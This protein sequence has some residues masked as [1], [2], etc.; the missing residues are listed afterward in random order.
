MKIC[1]SAGYI[2]WKSLALIMFQIVLSQVECLFLL[3]A[4]IKINWNECAVITLVRKCWR[5]VISCNKQIKTVH[6]ISPSM[7][8]SHFRIPLFDY[9]F[10]DLDTEFN[11]T[12]V[13]QKKY[14]A[15]FFLT[16]WYI[17]LK[18]IMT[19]K[20]SKHT[21]WWCYVSFVQLGLLSFKIV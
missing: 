13:F 7:L 3:Y 14:V 12:P 19:L 4:K 10:E 15:Y 8:F 18:E 21:F 2:H 9:T 1:I 17:H 20:V 6:D 11:L 16:Y 5:L